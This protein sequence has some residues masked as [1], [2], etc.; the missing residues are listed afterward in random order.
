MQ[1]T[2]GLTRSCLDC[3]LNVMGIHWRVLS[4]ERHDLSCVFK[5]A[6]CLFPQEERGR[7][8]VSEVATLVLLRTDGIV[9]WT[10]DKDVVS[11]TL[12]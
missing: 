6:F 7:K 8:E 2:G 12:I 4:S 10:R 9:T 1:K 5:R 11:S 3:N